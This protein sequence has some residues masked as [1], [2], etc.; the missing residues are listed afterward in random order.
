MGYY[1]AWWAYS[2]FSNFSAEFALLFFS[3]Y[4]FVCQNMMC[5]FA[6]KQGRLG[7]R[8]PPSK[9]L[10]GQIFICMFVCD[11]LARHGATHQNTPKQPHPQKSMHA[12]HKS[13]QDST[14]RNYI[15]ARH[16]PTGQEVHRSLRSRQAATQA[17]TT[18]AGRGCHCKSPA[19]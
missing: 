16:A 14:S 17:S 10:C 7:V 18:R 13:A 2:M 19:G 4:R 8:S 1:V 3:S 15:R 9:Q 12:A 11:S 5:Q 6:G